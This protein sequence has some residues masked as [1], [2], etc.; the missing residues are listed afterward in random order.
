MLEEAMAPPVPF[1]QNVID[2]LVAALQG[3]ADDVIVID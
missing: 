1:G 3:Q 2:E